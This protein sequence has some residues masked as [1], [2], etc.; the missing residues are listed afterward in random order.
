[1]RNDLSSVGNLKISNIWPKFGTHALIHHSFDTDNMYLLNITDF[2]SI[3]IWFEDDH[4]DHNFKQNNLP[5]KNH[6][7]RNLFSKT[8]P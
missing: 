4:N 6:F 1:M 7:L 3:W 8:R 5:Y 2:F